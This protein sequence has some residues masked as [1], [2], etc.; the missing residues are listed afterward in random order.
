MDEAK[1]L[2]L[3]EDLFLGKGAHKAAYVHPEDSSKCIKVPYKL[4]DTDV[5]RELEYRAVLRKQK[6]N[7]T[8]LTQYYGMVQTDKGQGYIYECVRDFDG[9]L[10]MSLIDLFAKQCCQQHLG[11]SEL[12]LM[13]QFRKQWMEDCIVTSDTDFVNYFAQKI[14]P[15]DFVIRIVDNV[16][17]PSKFPLAFYFKYFA[18]KRARKYWTRLMQRYIDTYCEDKDKAEAQRLL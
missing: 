1:V 9:S 4:P 14:S 2:V 11:V 13:Q 15:N 8:M 18:K 7:P 12:E 17:T 5:D 16:G 10:S 6:K 3:T